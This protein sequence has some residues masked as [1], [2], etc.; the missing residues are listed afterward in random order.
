M[1]VAYL[2]LV[3]DAVLRDARAKE[4]L[5]DPI[6]CDALVAHHEQLEA[7]AGKTIRKSDLFRDRAETME[8]LR[9]EIADE[10]RWTRGQGRRVGRTSRR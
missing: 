4:A 9:K 6:E 7:T 1:A 2:V 5:P 8:A 10:A 3:A